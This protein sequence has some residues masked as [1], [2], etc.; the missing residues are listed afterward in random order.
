M[1]GRLQ[2]KVCVI[3]GA[4]GG[5]G[6]A[7]ATRF[8]AEG[9]VVVG[10]DL[11]DDY[12]GVDLALTADVSDEAAVIAFLRAARDAYGRIDAAACA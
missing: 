1:S 4:A 11:R 3:T 10:V 5:I 2:D 12:E 9:A 6:A 7:T 8:R